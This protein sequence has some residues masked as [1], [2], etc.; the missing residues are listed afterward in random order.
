M[1]FQQFFSNTLNNFSPHKLTPDNFGVPSPRQHPRFSEPHSCSKPSLSPA[2]LHTRCVVDSFLLVVISQR[3]R[4]MRCRWR[5]RPPP[6]SSPSLKVEEKAV[7]HERLH[8]AAETADVPG[9][10]TLVEVRSVPGVASLS[11]C[12]EVPTAIQSALSCTCPTT[13]PHTFNPS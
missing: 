11:R 12:N 2:P 4:D 13:V 6:L 8:C 10:P 9:N 1:S 5:S 7:P 3:P